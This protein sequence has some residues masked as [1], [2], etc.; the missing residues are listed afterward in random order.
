MPRVHANSPQESAHD[1]RRRALAD[2]PADRQ[3]RHW[4][5]LAR[6]FDQDVRDG[7]ITCKVEANANDLG[8][9]HPA[10]QVRQNILST[11]PFEPHWDDQFNIAVDPEEAKKFHG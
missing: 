8:K 5:R 11:T 4:Y 9:G 3:A 2:R 10:A 6:Q 7:T 1:A